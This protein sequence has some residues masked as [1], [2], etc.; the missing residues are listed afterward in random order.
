MDKVT[1]GLIVVSSK[2]L[3]EFLFHVSRTL[4]PIQGFVIMINFSF[5]TN[6]IQIETAKSNDDVTLNYPK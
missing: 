3:S 6:V 2:L 5:N 1:T 4:S